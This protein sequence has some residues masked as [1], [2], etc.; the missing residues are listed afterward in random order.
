MNYIEQLFKQ[1]PFIYNIGGN[2]YALGTGVCE[3]VVS[4]SDVNQIDRW[5]NLYISMANENLTQEEARKIFVHL[6]SRGVN[7]RKQTEEHFNLADRLK[8]FG[9]SE[10]MYNELEK[11]VKR[12]IDFWKKN[13]MKDY[14]WPS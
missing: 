11:Q 4:D 1:H 13:N 12:Y 9:W 7:I 10:Q 14:D 3:Q 6:V 2:Y 8:Q 5:Y